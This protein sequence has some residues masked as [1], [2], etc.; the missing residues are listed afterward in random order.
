[1]YY[2]KSRAQAGRELAKQ[3]M[4][5]ANQNCAVIALNEGGVIVGAQIA[6]AIHANLML[7]ATTSIDLPREPKAIGGLTPTGAMVFNPE[8]PAGEREEMMV[9]YHN[10]I[11][12]KRIEK[13][14]E[15][16][17]L[18]GKTGA[19]DR[20]LLKRRVVVVVADGLPDGFLLDM[21]ADFLKPVLIKRLVLAV[22]VAGVQ[23]VD[24]MHLLG[25]ELHVLSVP[26]NYINT[27]HYFDSNVIPDQD[28]LFKVMQNISLEWHNDPKSSK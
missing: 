4:S 24:R 18:I 19:V 26:E 21:A 12:Q 25:D 9:E 13:F 27:D 17:T 14:H 6:M 5:Y 23:A 7:L 15:L 20:N 3:L 2:F 8:M 1:M 11:D 28:G 16:N 10:Y 22:P